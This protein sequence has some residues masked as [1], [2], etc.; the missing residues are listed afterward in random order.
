MSFA[1]SLDLHSNGRNV[2]GSFE[3]TGRPGNFSGSLFL[4]FSSSRVK[5]RFRMGGLRVCEGTVGPGG[6]R[7]TLGHPK[8]G[9]LGFLQG[10]YEYSVRRGKVHFDR[11]AQHGHISKNSVLLIEDG[12]ISGRLLHGPQ[13]TWAVDVDVPF[14]GIKDEAATLAVVLACDLILGYYHDGVHSTVND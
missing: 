7:L 6:A 2:T 5:G 14:T 4:S 10:R 13:E 12:R 1:W 11:T 3:Y 9:L 8:G